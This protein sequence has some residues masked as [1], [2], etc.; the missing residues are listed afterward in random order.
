MPCDTAMAAIQGADMVVT[1]VT[2]VPPPVPFLDA[3]WLE[4]GS[5][6]TMTDLALPWVPEAMQLFDRIVIDVIAHAHLVGFINPHSILPLMTACRDAS[7]PFAFSGTNTS[8]RIGT[9]ISRPRE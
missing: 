5:F 1:T 9:A 3:G 7:D 6:V 2:L 8:K 4:A